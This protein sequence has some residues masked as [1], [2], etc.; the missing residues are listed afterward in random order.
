LFESNKREV[1]MTCISILTDFGTKDGNVGVMKGVIWGIAPSVQISDLS[2]EISPQNILEGAFV[3]GRAAPFFPKGTVYLVVVD[4]GVGTERRSMAAEIGPY[5][6]VGPDN[7]VITMLVRHA[8]EREW[9]QQYVHLDRPQYWLPE[10]SHVFHGRDI[11]AP[12]AAHLATGVPLMDVGTPMNDPVLLPLPQPVRIQ[13]GISGKVIYIDRFG[14]LVTNIRTLDLRATKVLSVEI[15]D[16]RV[17]GLVETFGD[18]PP[19][20]LIALF[21]STGDLILSIVN[22]SA[23][24]VLD[25]GV[26]EKVKVN[27]TKS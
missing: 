21:S 26:G 14:S 2:N 22:G 5:R 9:S 24:R 16:S 13:D 7:G 27:F 11:F 19:G 25:V 20:S 18:R 23:S 6:F 4:P 3:L 15:K 17:D 12:V 1:I 10:V 8:V